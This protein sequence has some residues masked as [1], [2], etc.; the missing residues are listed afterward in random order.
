MQLV[1]PPQQVATVNVK[2]ENLRLAFSVGARVECRNRLV[3]CWGDCETGTVARL[4]TGGERAYGVWLDS[5]SYIMC[6]QCEY[7]IVPSASPPITPDFP[8]GSLVEC[9]LED[10]EFEWEPGVVVKCEKDWLRNGSP[11]YLIRFAHSFRH[12]WGTASTIRNYEAKEHD[13]GE[14]VEE[15]T[16]EL[17]FGAG[18]W[19]T[20]SGV[21][22]FHL[23]FVP[24]LKCP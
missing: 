10:A 4:W 5:G 12:F 18:N 17:R 1:D 9:K 3:P 21:Y 8:V 16:R 20:T 24:Q 15:V 6:T 13:W 22:I 11:P 7:S 19:G 2:P 14:A 23:V